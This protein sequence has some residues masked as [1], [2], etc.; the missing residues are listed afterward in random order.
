M[1]KSRFLWLLDNGHGGIINGEYM[2][3]G[4]RS[5]TWDDDKTLFEGEFNRAIVNRLAEMLHADGISYV[6]IAPQDNDV[7]LPERALR[8]KRWC[9]DNNCILVS[10]HSN[11]ANGKGI[12]SGVEVFTTV[13]KTDADKVAQ[14]FMQ[15]YKNYS[16][17]IKLRMDTE[18]GDWDKEENFYILKMVPCPAILTENFFMDNRDECLRWLL[19]PKGRDEIALIHFRAIKK[20]EENGL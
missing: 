9:K 12:A 4:K 6:K 14:V 15:E 18:D 2:T 13:G 11:Y 5:P 16:D 17:T 3:E 10:V 8:A 20:I 1:K 19:N 7:S